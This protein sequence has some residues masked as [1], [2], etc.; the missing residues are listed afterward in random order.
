MWLTPRMLFSK[1]KAD[2]HL[3]PDA[4]LREDG[5]QNGVGVQEACA[6]D[7]VDAGEGGSEVFGDKIGGDVPGEGSAYILQGMR[8]LKKCLVMTDIC[9]K[10]RIC[11]GD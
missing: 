8:G 9:Y 1:T 3:F 7:G 11:I 6:K 5:V 4:M 2:M 10:G